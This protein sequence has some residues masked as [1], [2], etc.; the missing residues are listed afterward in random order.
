[1]NCEECNCEIG[2][3]ESTCEECENKQKEKN[4]NE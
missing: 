4:K 3:W 1:M 2:G